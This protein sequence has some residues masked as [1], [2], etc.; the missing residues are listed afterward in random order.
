MVC[1][2]KYSA[3]MNSECTVSK[4]LSGRPMVP[5]TIVIDNF[6]CRTKACIE[7]HE[8]VLSELCKFS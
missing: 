4:K 5:R 3:N 6:I 1:G 2:N 7:S 8:N